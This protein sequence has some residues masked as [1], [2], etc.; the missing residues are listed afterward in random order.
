MGRI[1]GFNTNA[2]DIKRFETG[3]RDKHRASVYRKPKNKTHQHL[4]SALQNQLDMSL[5]FLVPLANAPTKMVTSADVP[6]Q[7][8]SSWNIGAQTRRAGSLNV[9][10]DRQENGTVHGRLGGKLCSACDSCRKIRVR[11]SGG[12]PCRKCEGTGSHCHYSPSLRN[13]RL[14]GRDHSRYPVVMVL[15]VHLAA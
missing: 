3:K 10:T 14:R 1:I 13:G 8:I 5:E 12:D 4:L 2:D 7:F 9:R 15:Q 11:C 6:E